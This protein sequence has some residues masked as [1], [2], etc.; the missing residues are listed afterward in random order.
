MTMPSK[1]RIVELAN[2]FRGTPIAVVGDLILDR[3]VWGKVERISPEAPV[4]VVEVVRESVHLGGAANVVAGLVAL[5]AVPF[6]VGVVGEDETGKTLLSEF[7]RQ[8][9]DSTGV[10]V[11]PERATSVKTRIVAHHQQVCR[12]D[13]EDRRP[14]DGAVLERLR[15][16]SLELIP[17]S[18]AVIL[19]DYA[20]GVLVPA[21]IADVISACRQE[22]RFVA[23]DPKAAEY[24]RYRGATIITPNKREAEQAAGV[25]IHD[26]DTLLAAGRVLLE[27]T[28]ARHVLVTRGEEG[29][30]LVGAD[31][32]LHLPT[33][34]REVFDV[35]G[36]GDTVIAALTLAAAVGASLPE[37]AFF[38]NHA[39][40]VVVGKVGTASATVEEIL[41]GIET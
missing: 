25:R 18:R 3:F 29:I 15:T 33:A 17:R 38:A 35:T 28:A 12:T 11:D 8:G 41:A 20:K 23:V 9:V 2:R 7:A 4:P 26:D 32:E 6:P 1:E 16:A 10:V 34:A 5:G 27:R 39:A 22:G 19:S 21:L 40:G 13:R 31:G 37:A 30:T 36:A 14:V 24:S